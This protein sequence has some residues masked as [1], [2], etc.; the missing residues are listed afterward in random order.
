MFNRLLILTVLGCM[1]W[2]PANI[3][4]ASDQEQEQMQTEEQERVYGWKLMTP[5][6][7]AEHLA[8]I[9]S[10]KTKEERKAYQMEHHKL[11]EERA[12]KQ[13]VNLK[14]VP[15]H[16]PPEKGRGMGTGGGRGSGG[17]RGR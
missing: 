7:R 16:I 3:T 10:L 1:I 8:T 14:G 13:G 5:E 12:R 15:H 17:G 11:M 9:R 2:L 6:E 4:M